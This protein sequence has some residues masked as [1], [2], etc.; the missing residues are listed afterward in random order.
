MKKY[1]EEIKKA[2]RWFD[3]HLLVRL[4]KWRIPV[5]VLAALLLVFVIYKKT[6]GS[7]PDV[8]TTA[9]RFGDFVI[10]INQSGELYAV[11]SVSVGVP[12]KVRGSLRVVALAED[13][14]LVRTGDFLVQFD[15][16]EASQDLEDRRNEYES[17]LADLASLQASNRS[18]MAQLNTAYETEQYSF[19]QAK[20]RY[21]QMKYEAPSKQREQELS[22]KK[23]TLSLE[24]AQR[25]IE[26][27]EIINKA[28]LTKS[29]LKLRQ[30]RLRY[31]QKAQELNDLTLR[32]PIDGMVVLQEI[33]GAN[34]RAKV[35]V[36]DSPFRGQTLVE[37]P[38]LATMMVKAK[39]NEVF[40]S[41]VHPDQQAVLSVDALP[42]QQFYGK[43]LRVATLASRESDSEVKTFDVEIL[44]DGADGRLR[45]GMT[46]QCQIITDR[47]KDKLF[48]PL[49]SVVH[50]DDTTIVYIKKG[51]FKR[52]EVQIGPKNS[53]FIV[54]EKGLKQGD[55]VALRD[56]TLPVTA[57]GEKSTAAI[58]EKRSERRAP[59]GRGAIMI[60]R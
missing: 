1:L 13:G 40:I 54:I 42:G 28:D 5:L 8:A 58:K 45:P 26:S 21:E 19:E 29:N 2:W 9:A 12:A 36:G 39:V 48:V 57:A 20:L 22:L 16:A 60:M 31:E 47:I 25:K 38:D 41:Q 49:E 14:S 59:G 24:Q 37:I 34:G 15:T 44:I 35:K 52:R 43:V 23:A 32:A 51:G 3:A 11:K 6:L 55:L 56:P 4:G 33:W 17:A 30:A 7:V 53:D 46:A 50:K 18:T 27:Q 10:D